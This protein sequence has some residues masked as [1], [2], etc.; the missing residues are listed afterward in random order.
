MSLTRV[1]QQIV[2]C[3]R[4]PRLRAYCA[5]VARDRKPAH[6]HDVY[7][8]KPVPG[9]GDARARLLVLGLAPAAH[10]ANRTG[11]MFTGD[12]S[13]DFLM[14]ALHRTGFASRPASRAADDGL[15]LTDAYITA[16]VRCAPPS[17]KPAVG[18][19]AACRVHLEAE[20]LELRRIAVVVALGRIAFD[21]YWDLPAA[22][23][24]R[25]V[26]RP[27]FRHGARYD[28]GGGPMVIASYH[29]SRQ[30]TNTG[31]LTPGML[32]AVFRAARRILTRQASGEPIETAPYG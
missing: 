16:A 27:S 19:I 21:S 3:R 13:G 11:R 32:E 23:A 5:R 4:C 17:N 30:N 26:P 14:T 28:P 10:G 22:R 7:W 20:L 29:P 6:R 12:G 25:P 8:G 31:R 24:V 9:F 1:R 2:A 18:E 15:V